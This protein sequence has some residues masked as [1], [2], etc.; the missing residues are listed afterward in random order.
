MKKEITQIEQDYGF[1]NQ[2]EE[3]KEFSNEYLNTM[4]DESEDILLEDDY[5]REYF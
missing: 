5:E 3:N 2:T 4:L 1:D